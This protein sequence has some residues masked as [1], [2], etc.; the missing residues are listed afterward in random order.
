MGF[1][2]SISKI[3]KLMYAAKVVA[4]VKAGVTK[5]LQLVESAVNAPM[6]AMVQQVV[7][8]AWKGHGADAFVNE[9]KNMAQPRALRIISIMNRFNVDLTKAG[10]VINNADKVV[11]QKVNDLAQEIGAIVGSMK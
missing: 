11:N 7:N 6:N 3:R 5:Q 2:S 1:F 4:S 8:G 10:D 9:V